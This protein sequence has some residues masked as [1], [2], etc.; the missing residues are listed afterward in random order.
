ML[1]I[2]VPAPVQDYLNRLDK[3]VTDY[4]QVI[5]I[6]AVAEFMGKHPDTVREMIKSGTGDFGIGWKRNTR[7]EFYIPTAQFWMSALKPILK[8]EKVWL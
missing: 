7:W 5:P 8:G 6:D 2:T 1:N 4:P 3:L